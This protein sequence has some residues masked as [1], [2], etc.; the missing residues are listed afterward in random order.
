LLSSLARDDW[1]ASFRALTD[2]RPDATLRTEHVLALDDRRFLAVRRWVGAES[3]GAF[4]IPIVV[5]AACSASELRRLHL[6]DLDQL[7]SDSGS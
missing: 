1:V 5:A 3:E 7:D 2:L 6:Y 4:E